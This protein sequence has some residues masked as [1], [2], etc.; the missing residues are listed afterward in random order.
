M[1]PKSK[2]L[3]SSPDTRRCCS[4]SLFAACVFSS[5]CCQ[6]T[7]SFGPRLSQRAVSGS[8]GSATSSE[9][10]FEPATD[11][12]A[13]TM[14]LSASAVGSCAC[15]EAAWAMASCSP[16]QNVPSSAIVR[17]GTG[18]GDQITLYD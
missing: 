7:G 10:R 15:K 9:D 5:H 17:N 14:T 8:V 6:R 13:G 2:S 16:P 12:A 1:E 11:S 18:L 3:I 4:I